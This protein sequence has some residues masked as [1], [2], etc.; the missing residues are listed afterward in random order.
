MIFRKNEGFHLPQTV[1]LKGGH[2][3]CLLPSYPGESSLSLHG[4]IL[5]YLP[6]LDSKCLEA[7]YLSATGDQSELQEM[8]VGWE[9]A[10]NAKVRW[11]SQ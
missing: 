8:E 9:G 4:H 10:A 5:K 2:M 3:T 1:A 7:S 11:Q 6:N